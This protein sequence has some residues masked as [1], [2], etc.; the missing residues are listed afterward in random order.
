VVINGLDLG[1]EL[2]STNDEVVKVWYGLG[3]N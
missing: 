1:F 3:L 2:D